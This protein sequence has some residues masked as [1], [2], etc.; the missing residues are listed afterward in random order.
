MLEEGVAGWSRPRG[1]GCCMSCKLRKQPVLTCGFCCPSALSPCAVT[2]TLP[3]WHVP[4]IVP[5]ST[6]DLYSFQVSPMPSTSEGLCPCGPHAC[7]FGSW[8]G[9]PEGEK[10][11]RTL[12]GTDRDDCAV[13]E[14]RGKGA[15]GLYLGLRLLSSLA[16]LQPSLCG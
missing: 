8:G 13:L 3:D 6:S 15:Q 16:P 12:P 2:S 14:K 5:D 9:F 4:E 10:M 1:Q 11:L 7:L